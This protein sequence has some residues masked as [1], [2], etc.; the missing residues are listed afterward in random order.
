MIGKGSTRKP[1][2]L[3][4]GELSVPGAI[5]FS[6]IFRGFNHETQEEAS[7]DSVRVLLYF[8]FKNLGIGGDQSAKLFRIERSK[9]VRRR[10]RSGHKITSQSDSELGKRYS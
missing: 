10:L 5:G 3:A 8:S 1:Y 2:G 9:K 7:F 6:N 4:I